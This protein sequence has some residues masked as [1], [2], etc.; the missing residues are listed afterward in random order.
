VNTPPAPTTWKS[1]TQQK[2]HRW[3]RRILLL[4]IPVLCIALPVC[5][6]GRRLYVKW[7]Q[8]RLVAKS[9]ADMEAGEFHDAALS[10]QRVLQLNPGNLEAS[11][12]F[13]EL[14]DRLE[15]PEAVSLRERVSLLL[16]DSFDDAY[17][18]ASTALKFNNLAVAQ[19]GFMIM[20]KLAPDD[21][22]T[23]E[24]EARI[25]LDT[26]R[27]GLAQTEFATS[28]K[29]D[30]S[31]EQVQLE[32]AI[33]NIEAPD[34]A[35]REAARQ[36]L[37]RLRGVQ[38]THIGALRTLAAIYARSGQT[39]LAVPLAKELA[40]D[41]KATFQ[42]R[43]VY[44]TILRI[45]GSADFTPYLSGLQQDAETTPLNAAMLAGWMNT[46][47]LALLARDWLRKLPA[48]MT[49]KPPVALKLAESDILAE[50]WDALMALTKDPDWESFEFMRLAYLSRAFLEKG[51]PDA[52]AVQWD[53]A[54]ALANSKP[55][56]LDTL[57]KTA[58]SWGWD[59]RLEKLLWSIAASSNHPQEAL[60]TLAGRYEKV[61]DTRDLYH[62][63]SELLDHDVTNSQLKNDWAMLSLLLQADPNGAVQAAED[64]Y[65]AN[66]T[67][68]H[69]AAT[70]AFALFMTN[71]TDDALAVMQKLPQTDLDIPSIS[72]YYGILLAAVRNPDA[73]KY[74]NQA[75][76][77]HFLP[78]EESLL[79]KA[80][81]QMGEK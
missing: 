37:E 19:E 11:R 60:Q 75:K 12:L 67:N 58:A 27:K 48:D 53:A 47:R 81:S 26:G 28:L 49:R 59:G 22:K 14:G 6:Y 79:T 32:S 65:D 25:D 64:L 68:P 10:L 4:L 21:A 36:T 17:A 70:Y 77:V 7:E 20:K 30:P 41:P 31:N 8:T 69:V 56:Q 61:G 76:G 18:L 52:S 16:P 57:E 78:E 29:L 50:D 33:L 39:G 51:N 40:A 74:L 15:T 55:G 3:R 9:R 13:A 35:A 62:V 34:A 72:A 54:V 1:K 46:H 5:R 66:S 43:L 24:I 23:H 42:D 45:S 63:M 44:L 38:S 80:R 73:T 71:R 2:E